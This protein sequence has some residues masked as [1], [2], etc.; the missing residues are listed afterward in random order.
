MKPKHGFT[1]I[2]LLVVIAIIAIL[3]AILFPVFAQAREKARA[4]SCL[5]NMKQIGLGLVMYNQDYDETM[6]LAFAQPNPIN[7][8]GLNDIPIDSQL[9]PY[10]KND[11]VWKCPSDSTELADT[12]LGDFWDGSYEPNSTNYKRSYA[13]VGNIHTVQ[14]EQQ[15]GDTSTDGDPNT[16]MSQW[17][18]PPYVPTTLAAIE[19]PADTVG[20]VENWDPN[21][22]ASVM[23][24]PWGALFT[25]CDTYK[26]AGRN[27]P[28]QNG[29]DNWG[30]S[31]GSACYS[32]YQQNPPERGHMSFANYSFTDGHAK[33]LT[34]GA[35]RHNDFWYFKL[36]K[37][38]Q[39]FS[40]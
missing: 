3:A 24:S 10:I 25:A 18:G 38:T 9:K 1:L 39:V 14:Y 35:I 23:G 12:N 36:S 33:A 29:G 20:I 7:N 13:Y 11:Q 37:P 34:W 22:G 16:G 15:T 17:G 5:S 32:T 27:Y 30:G 26:L 2:E 8:G 6:P 19:Q 40:P 21:E 4:I 31:S 28:A